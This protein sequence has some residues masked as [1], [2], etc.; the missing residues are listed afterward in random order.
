[1]T[2]GREGAAFPTLRLGFEYARLLSV[3]VEFR[4]THL[5]NPSPDSRVVRSVR[6]RIIASLHLDTPAGRVR[7]R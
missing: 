4:T 1:M 7:S 6:W 2:C 3:S 5:E